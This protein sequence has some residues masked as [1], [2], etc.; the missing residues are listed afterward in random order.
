MP[1]GYIDFINS[2]LNLRS[3]RLKEEE[4]E[5]KERLIQQEQMMNM[6]GDIGESITKFGAQSTVRTRWLTG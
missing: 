5:Q 1:G 2:M 6:V 3:Q 4:L